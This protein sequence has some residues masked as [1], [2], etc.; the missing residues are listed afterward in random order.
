MFL[1]FARNFQFSFQDPASPIMSGIIDLHHDIFFF[2][3]LI[4]IPVLF[5]FTKIISNSY[6]LWLNPT[7]EHINTWRKDNLA[8]TNLIHG[9][10]LEIVW[11][12]LPAIILM[13]IAIPSFSLLYSLDEILDATYTYKVVGNQW[14][15]HY[16]TP[17]NKDYDSYM[18][19]DLTSGE[20]RLLEVDQP[21]VCPANTHLRFI[22]T[23][24]DVLHSFA[25]PSLGIKVDAVPG[26][27]NS[28]ST[29]I[30]REGFF[31]GQCSE[32][33]GVN[34]GFMPITLIAL[35]P[36]NFENLITFEA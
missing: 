5:I 20:F 18:R 13:F 17:D 4:L 11:T 31:S 24:A 14:Y 6:I 34:H 7:T 28:I 1:D 9:T 26:R 25:I 36:E 33:C 32:L 22:I 29:Y 12:I 19:N 27:L 8:I 2:L 15:W 10:I 35:S 23:A 3:L 21:L 30:Q 16:E